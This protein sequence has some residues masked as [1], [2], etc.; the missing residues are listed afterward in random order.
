MLGR[1][2]VAQHLRGA[3]GPSPPT[4]PPAE[5]GEPARGR[6]CSLDSPRGRT[7][8]APRR[9]RAAWAA[10]APA[11]SAESRG[12]VRVCERETQS[13]VAV[14]SCASR[15]HSASSSKA[16]VSATM[17]RECAGG[18]S[19]FRSVRSALHGGGL[20]SCNSSMANA[21]FALR[22]KSV[23]P[24]LTVVEVLERNGAARTVLSC[25]PLLVR[26]PSFVT[27]GPHFAIGS[28]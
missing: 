24:T 19:P 8:T 9:A 25:R 14:G 7:C 15:A 17:Q 6:L 13:R 16:R 26:K 20:A 4:H 1:G 3:A 21:Q 23:R 10:A 27:S 18:R 22:A 12:G 2:R 11:G 28:L 5:R